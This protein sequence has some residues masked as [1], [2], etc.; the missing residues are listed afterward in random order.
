MLKTLF[1]FLIFVATAAN[2]QTSDSLVGN[3]KFKDVYGAEKLDS[4]ARAES[5][6]IF[7]GIRI[8]LK[9]DNHYTAF[10]FKKEEGTWTYDADSKDLVLT[11]DKGGDSLRVI[12][13]TAKHLIIEFEKGKGFVLEKERTE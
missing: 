1:A 10:L 13:V 4:A 12:E 2:A 3:W 8:Q 9:P 11:H 7:G 5:K 6:I